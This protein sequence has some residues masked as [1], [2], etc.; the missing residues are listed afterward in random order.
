MP[1]SCLGQGWHLDTKV[2]KSSLSPHEVSRLCRGES[3]TDHVLPSGTWGRKRL[4]ATALGNE[5]APGNIKQVCSQPLD[6]ERT[7]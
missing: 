6:L 4:T 7:L 3:A 1:A 2:N 5:E